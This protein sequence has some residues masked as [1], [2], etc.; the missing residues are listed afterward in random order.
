M[1]LFMTMA[2]AFIDIQKETHT[3]VL[4]YIYIHIAY[5]LYSSVYYNTHHDSCI[6][7][8]IY[9]YIPVYYNYIQHMQHII[10]CMHFLLR[11][12]DD[13]IVKNTHDHDD[14]TRNPT[15]VY[16]VQAVQLT[17]QIDWYR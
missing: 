15:I 1:P 5:I 6:C 8:Y 11:A 13:R 2:M 16:R 12:P 7:I 4:V 9:I 10:V 3:T 17:H 14:P